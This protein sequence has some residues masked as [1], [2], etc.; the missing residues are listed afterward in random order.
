MTTDSD[1]TLIARSVEE[2]VAAHPIVPGRVSPMRVLDGAGAR[3][4]HLAI[5]AGAEL[6]EHKAPAP[7]LIQALVGEVRVTTADEDVTLSPGGSVHIAANVPH[8]VSADQD[9]HMLLV[10][11]R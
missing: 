2:L 6:R 1:F 7:I 4:M 10:L 5:A 9:A 3:V 11:L 8:A